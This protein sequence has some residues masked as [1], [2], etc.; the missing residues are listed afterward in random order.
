MGEVGVRFAFTSRSLLILSKENAAHCTNII[1]QQDPVSLDSER[2]Y[3]IR[4]C[5]RLHYYSE[6]EHS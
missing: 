4:F 1:F 6:S 2:M 3:R 5:E